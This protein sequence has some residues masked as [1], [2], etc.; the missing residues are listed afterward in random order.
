MK[1]AVVC[2]K[3]I[4]NEEKKMINAIKDAISKKY[5]C[6]IVRF[7]EDFLRK[8]NKYD[9]V[10]NLSNKGGKEVKQVHVPSVL[11]FL[12]IPYTSSNTFTHAICL[13]KITTKII[14]KQYNIPTPDFYVVDVGEIPN[15]IDGKYIVK[16]PREGSA[17]GITKDSIV[18][19]L[20]DLKKQVKKIHDEFSQPALV[21]KFIDGRE[22]SVGV[23]G[24]KKPEVLPILEIDFSSLPKELERFYSYRVK[25]YYG[26]QT[27]YICPANLDVDLEKKIKYYAQKLFRVLNLRDYARMDLRIK[28]GEIYFLEVNSMPQL[29]PVY[30]DITKMAKAAGC[31]YDKLVLK[32]LEIS[33]E[34][35]GL[36]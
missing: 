31:D 20:E 8:I 7:D 5:K 24:N 28:G 13:D 16:P 23:I 22:F 32:I 11:D 17:K 25:H 27:R 1:I 33:M 29:V 10:F 26:E 18:D 15:Y 34:R 14:M 36:L 6:E 35:W 4:N 9:F 12:G 30:S 21:E 2:D 19:N 3:N